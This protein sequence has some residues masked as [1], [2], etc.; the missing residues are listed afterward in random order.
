MSVA[1]IASLR[2]VSV[3]S[4]IW[5]HTLL[6]ALAYRRRMGYICR[7][8]VS[9]LRLGLGIGT[10]RVSVKNGVRVTPI[11][12]RYA[13]ALTSVAQIWQCRPYDV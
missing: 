9:Q 7:Y 1:G 3:T 6:N 13:N 11:Q 5:P 4:K 8:G 2:L 10:V 12:H